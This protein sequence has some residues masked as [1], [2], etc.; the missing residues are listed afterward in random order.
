MFPS[1]GTVVLLIFTRGRPFKPLISQLWVPPPSTHDAVADADM[2][3]APCLCPEPEP[4]RLLPDT[5]TQLLRWI[6][7]P[8]QMISTIGAP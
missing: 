1:D 4:P 7:I 6:F 3:L 8:Q 2:P 5:A